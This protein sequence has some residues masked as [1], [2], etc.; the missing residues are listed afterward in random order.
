MFHVFLLIYFPFKNEDLNARGH[1]KLSSFP[2]KFKNLF[3]INLIL[4]KLVNSVV[5]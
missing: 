3:K 5:G 2:I 1:N 4:K